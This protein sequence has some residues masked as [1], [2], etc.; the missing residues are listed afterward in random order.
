M[1]NEDW[2]RSAVVYQIYPRSFA[3]G[4]GDGVGDLA[5]IRA[6]LPYLAELGVD[7]VWISPWYASPMADGGYD[8]ADYRDID[9]LFGSLAE[10]ERLIAEAHALG[11][12]I[13]IDLVP[14]HCSDQHP[15]FA[16]AVAA[17][18]GSPQRARFHFRPGRGTAG[19]LPPNDW[20]SHFGGPAWTRVADGE[21]YL[22]LF[23]SE[24]PDF[25]WDHPDV[26]AEFEDVLRFWLDRGVDG[27]RIDV[28]DHLAKAPGLPEVRDYRARDANDSPWTDQ[29]PVH[30][31]YRSW[32]AL[33]D[34][35]EGERVFVGEIWLEDRDRFRAY[36]RPDEL[37]TAFN[38]PF[39]STAWDAEAL[40][41]VIDRTFADHG[42][43][44]AVP[45]WVLSNHDVIRHVTRYG[46]ADTRHS[47]DPVTEGV[48]VD[49][50]LGRRRARAAALLTLALPG[51]AYVYQG[52][53][54]GLAEVEDIAAE[55]IQDP[56]WP[57]SGFTD[58]GRD[59]CRVPLPWSGDGAPY[60]FSPEGATN[61][62]WLPQPPDWAGFSAAA[63]QGDPASTLE[64]YRAA[65][66]LRRTEPDL[67][68]GEFAWLPA[69]DGVL[70]FTR[71]AG[72]TCLVNLAAEAVE[73]PPRSSLLLASGPLTG[74]GLLPGGT[75][76]W[77]RT[78]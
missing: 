35:Y 70:A 16:E 38:F 37:H 11:L 42:P 72:F 25:D 56:R 50:A 43:I 23:A 60:G 27:F 41:T 3:D 19:E 5:G 51:C 1:K 34:S 62:P 4:N 69:P 64:L 65:L 58:R 52:E 53:E 36:L 76:V 12:R 55:L 13:I 22:H 32:R 15:W 26:R 63:Q 8:V 49:L 66:G 31:V 39:L 29:D 2:L 40:R 30:E 6:R 10:A 33:A 20:Q 18:P 48:P 17:G 61:T 9:P 68:A 21:W 75:A 67:V 78:A 24:Q 73:L 7:A 45:T 71:G 57:R 46:R 77:M 59:G 54:L 74:S 47:W 44:G 14:N 28:A